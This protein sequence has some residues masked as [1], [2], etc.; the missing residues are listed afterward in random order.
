MLALLLQ[1]SIF[2]VIISGSSHS[3][4]VNTT[5]GVVKGHTI[6]VINR[7]I[8]EF[9]AIPY[10][11]PPIDELRF[12]KPKPITVPIRVSY[13]QNIMNKLMM[14]QNFYLSNLYKR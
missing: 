7:S 4:Y 11:E 2:V 8:H 12:A 9:L 13:A 5:S 1:W 10:A 14:T 3:L 6:F